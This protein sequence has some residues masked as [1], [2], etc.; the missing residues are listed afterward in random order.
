MI[1]NHLKSQANCIGIIISEYTTQVVILK[2]KNRIKNVISVS[3][4]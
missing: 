1:V 2:V 4:I 3:D